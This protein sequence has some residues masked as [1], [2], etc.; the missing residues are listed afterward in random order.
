MSAIS[1]GVGGSAG[2]YLTLRT[3]RSATGKAWRGRLYS[4]AIRRQENRGCVEVGSRRPF[5]VMLDG[6]VE[7]KRAGLL[8]GYLMHG[9]FFA[10]PVPLTSSVY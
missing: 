7:T 1:D 10:L 8:R 4:A 3:G 5:D 6:I 2:S 9:E